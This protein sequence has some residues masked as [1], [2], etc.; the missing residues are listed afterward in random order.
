MTEPRNSAG[1]PLEQ[2]RRALDAG[3]IDR[4]TFDAALAGMSADIAGGGAIA[5]G[6]SAQAVGVQGVGIGRDHQGRI[7]TGQEIA[8]AEGAQIVY[9]EQGA[10]VVIGDA[11]VPMTA[12]D[13]RSTVGRYLQH[14][15]AQNRYLQLQGIRSGGK[16][17]NIE[18]DRIYVTLRTTRQAARRTQVGWLEDETALAPGERH[19]GKGEDASAETTPVTVNQALADHRR[20]VVLGD[21]GSGKTTLLRYLALLYAR[22]LAEGTHRVGNQLGLDERGSLP[23]L[24]P[25]RQIGRYLAEHR[26]KDDGTEGHAILL[27]FL[28]RILENERIP[29]PADFFDDW[30]TG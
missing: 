22:D 28:A 19:R 7:N 26:P 10:T 30:L 2:L 23:I 25:L 13:R 16:L 8:A 9:A 24:L 5:Q 11:P 21:P 14:L 3:L 17:V 27:D 4:A 1:T 6:P 12:V 29:V 20:L 18:L 15:I